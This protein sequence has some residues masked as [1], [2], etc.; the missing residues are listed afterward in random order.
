LEPDF[1][2]PKLSFIVISHNFERYILQCLESIVNQTYRNIEII[3]VD[4][5][6]E[7]KTSEII[8]NFIK[9]QNNSIKIK[10]IKNEKNSGQL[11]SF[12]TGLE[13]AEGQFVAQ[14]DGDDVLFREYAAM[15]IET[16][17]QTPVAL[18]T[19]QQIEIDGENNIHTLTSVDSP[20][21]ERNEFS[22][23]FKT[24]SEFEE[25]RNGKNIYR[26]AS[27]VKVLDNSKYSFATWHWGPSS[28][29]VMRKSVCDIL[30]KLNREK[31]LKITADKFIFSFAHLIGS[32]AIIYKPLYAYRRHTS[33]YSL[34]N[35][36]MGNKKYFN[37]ATQNNYF[38][39]NRRIR[40]QMFRFIYENRQYFREKF[41]KSNLM[42]IY[43][44]I[45]FSFDKNTLKG[46]FKALFI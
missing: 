10:F 31:N 6:S 43:K 16:H 2:L 36:V 15:H 40:T 1:N 26:E 20:L 32:S 22:V 3:I 29:G 5:C 17:M 28:S 19:C 18:T 46:I 37:P 14:I 44:R 21:I 33:N 27:Q 23:P 4:D 38:R 8:E 35:P 25:Y 9:N 13:Q 12:L 11:N 45:I 42:L 24:L 41:N 34:A 39:N 7:D 30:L